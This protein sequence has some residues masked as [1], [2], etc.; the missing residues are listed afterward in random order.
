MSGPRLVYHLALRDLHAAAGAQF[1]LHAGWSLPAHYGDEAS[2]YHALRSTAAVLDRSHRSRFLV[3]GTDALEVLRSAL[4][5]HVEELDEGRAM[6]SVALDGAGRIRD[7][8]LIARTGSIAYAVF[9]EPGQR[10]ETLARLQAALAPDFDARIDD[11]TET[12]CLVALQGP[13]AAAM[14]REH[15]SDALPARLQPLHC[16]VFE[17]HGFRTLALRTGDTGEDGFEFMVA[18]AVAQ[19]MIETLRGAGLPL[20]GFRAWNSARIEACVPAFDPDLL[21]GLTPAQ[22]DLDWLLD[23]PAGAAGTILAALLIEGDA[24]PETGASVLVGDTAAGQ[25]RSA[26]WAPGLGSVAALALLDERYALPGTPLAV[27]H[28]RAA[29]AAKP[30]FRRRTPP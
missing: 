5:G 13:G 28:A 26:A 21:G 29:V 19:H 14:A 11:R 12:T 20:C 15:L 16:A 17:F 27:G 9:G 25:V 10:Q 4:A 6:R 23:V 3:T 7:L 2:E 1:Q 30:L 22:A 24:I 8:V 18:P